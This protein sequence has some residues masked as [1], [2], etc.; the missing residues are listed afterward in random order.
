MLNIAPEKKPQKPHK[1]HKCLEPEMLSQEPIYLPSQIST[2][3][4][5]AVALDSPAADRTS[6]TRR[7]STLYVAQSLASRLCPSL[8][9]DVDADAM[10]HPR[11]HM[12]KGREI[13]RSA[14]LRLRM[15]HGL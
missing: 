9:R 14:G 2:A 6:S 5:P 4:S 13:E 8:R 12:R 11:V 15:R 1:P 7:H 3:L 10:A